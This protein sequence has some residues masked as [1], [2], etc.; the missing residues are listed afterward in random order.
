MGI[1]VDVNGSWKDGKPYVNVNGSWKEVQYAYAN[2]N[3]SWKQVFAN[4]NKAT[5]GTITD[6]D[7]YNG[8]GQKWRVHEFKSNSTFSVQIAAQPFHVLVCGGGGGGGYAWSQFNGGGPGIGGKPTIV[9]NALAVGS[10]AVTIG[11]G[12]HPVGG[13]YK[14]GTT[15]GASSLGNIT[16]NGGS[17]GAFNGGYGGN[18]YS[19]NDR[20]KSYFNN[21]DHWVDS[22]ITGTTAKYGR[23]GSPGG[24]QFEFASGGFPGGGGRGG[25]SGWGTGGHPQNGSAGVV[26]VAYQI[27]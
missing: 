5:G 15:G 8:T 25:G 19:Q 1:P 13:N 9:T 23:N 21:P 3:G 26:I 16:G 14:R 27:G 6:V 4:F 18:A 7:N 2:V 11:G 22:D 20:V 24:P 12:G 17:G 10:F